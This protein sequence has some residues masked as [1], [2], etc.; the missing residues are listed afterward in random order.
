MKSNILKIRN[1]EIGVGTPKICAPIVEQTEEEIIAAALSLKDFPIDIVEWR[2]D[3][4]DFVNEN[5]AI[6][7]TLGALRSTLGDIPLLF[8]IRTAAE[9]GKVSIPDSKYADIILN[10]AESGFADLIDVEIFKPSSIEPREISASLIE[11]VHSAG[12][13]VIASYHNFEF[14]PE[15]AELIC[16]HKIMQEL[17]ADICKLAVM[18]KSKSDVALLL[19]ATLKISSKCAKVPLVTVSMSGLGVIS[20]L[21][22]EFYGSSITFG[23]T[24][25]CSAPGQIDISELHKILSLL[26][27][28]L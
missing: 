4:F 10:T 1:L 3:H 16:R 6:I 2:A 15:E 26:H 11:S 13:N 28:L 8:T 25:K 27:N 17:N 7:E 5:K 9:G 20:R 14:T 12:A 24:G 18:P 23:S 19:D 22:P 21:F